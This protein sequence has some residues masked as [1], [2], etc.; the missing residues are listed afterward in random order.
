MT[1]SDDD[2]RQLLDADEVTSTTEEAETPG[3]PD[4]DVV[5]SDPIVIENVVVVIGLPHQRRRFVS[6]LV[7]IFGRPYLGRAYV[8]QSRLSVVVVVCD[9]LYCGKT[10][11]FS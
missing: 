6:L 4:S 7:T 5:Q 10:V 8:I 2:S 3:N 1:A 9:I 11:H